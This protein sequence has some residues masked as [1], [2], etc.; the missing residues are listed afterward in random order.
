[1]LK[2]KAHMISNL[3]C[4]VNHC[5]WVSNRGHC[6]WIKSWG[7][8]FYC[9]FLDKGFSEVSDFMRLDLSHK[10]T[11]FSLVLGKRSVTQ[12]LLFDKQK[13]CVI[14]KPKQLQ[15]RKQFW[16]KIQSKLN[17]HILISLLYNRGKTVGLTHTCGAFVPKV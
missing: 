15:L 10:V 11:S 8:T 14:Y 16:W 12:G 5:I 9:H 7:V 3:P 6:D 4:K 1:M 2:F 13:Y 17:S